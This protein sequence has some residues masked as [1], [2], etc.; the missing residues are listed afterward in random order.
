MFLGWAVVVVSSAVMPVGDLGLRGA[1][2]FVHLISVPVGFGAA[3]MMNI[4][5]VLWRLGHQSLRDVLG[6][7]SVAHRLLAGGLAGL[8]ATGIALDPDLQDPLMR[9]K[10][11]LLLALMLNAARTQHSIGHLTALAAGDTVPRSVTR[12][13]VGSAAISQ[14]AW[15]G[16]I[17][18]GF[19]TTTSR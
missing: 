9:V 16:T 2:L 17:V 6:L 3:V 8:I 11:G 4:Y 18:I 10:L 13:V 7:I 19:V 14:I 1:A 15:W 5:M 12:H